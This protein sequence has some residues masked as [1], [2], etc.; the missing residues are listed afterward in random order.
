MQLAER[1]PNGRF[2]PPATDAEIAAVES[3]LN[4]RF[5]EQLRSLYLQ[6]DGFR[7]DIGNAKYL[8]S[9]TNHDGIGSLRSITEFCWSEFTDTWP[10]L[11]LTPYLFFGSSNGDQMWGIRWRDGGEIIAFHH[12][13]EGTYDVVGSDILKVYT[14]N[15]ASYSVDD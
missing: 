5:P 13:M 8:Y 9:L 4:V 12:H 1:F 2:Q 14:E 6:C 15:Y 3:A 11:D 7:E 10:E